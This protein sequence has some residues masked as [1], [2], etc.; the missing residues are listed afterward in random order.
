MGNTM[1]VTLILR[2]SFNDPVLYMDLVF[3]R[4]ALLFDLSRLAFRKLLRISDV[5][6][7]HR[8][9]DHFRFDQ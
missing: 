1:G 7:T 9:M 3:E 8:H 5:L 6:V 4:R 2:S